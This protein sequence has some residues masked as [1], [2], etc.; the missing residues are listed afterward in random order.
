MKLIQF[1]LTQGPIFAKIIITRTFTIFLKYNF[2]KR[3]GKYF[4]FIFVLLDSGGL[5]LLARQ[6]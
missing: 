1:F 6:N 5:K 2:T 4:I 3:F